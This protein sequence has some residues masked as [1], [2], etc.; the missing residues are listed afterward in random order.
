MSKYKIG[1]VS[2]KLG[3]IAGDGDMGTSLTAIGDTVAGSAAMETTE[4]TVQDFKIEESDSPVLSI[5]TEADKIVI[6]WS[7]YNNSADALVK[8]FGGTKVAATTD[9]V[10]TIGSI[11][12]GSLYTDGTYTDVALTGGTGTGAKATIVVSGGAVTGVTITSPGNGY[13]A[14][15]SLTASAADIGGTGSGFAVAVATVADTNEQWKAP[16]AIPEIEQ[17][18]EAAW[19][20]GGKIQVPRAKITAKLSMS[21]K[22]DALSQ[23][24]ISASVLQPTKVGVPRMT[25]TSDAG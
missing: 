18:L 1:L 21:F 22:R 13:T 12:A 5:K 25:I 7:T 3:D 24:D 2:M 8:L 11:T 17:S 15:D 6:N 4:A 9:G 20:T 14:A 16:D 23:V 10:A 19:K